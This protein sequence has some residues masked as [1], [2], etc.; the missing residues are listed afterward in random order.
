MKKLLYL[1]LIPLLALSCTREQEPVQGESV[2][3]RFSLDQSDF[4]SLRQRGYEDLINSLELWVF[5]EQGLFV[6]KAKEVV[7]N[8]SA[9]S[10][11]AKI[12]KS[13]APRIIH[14]V[15]NY[16]LANEANWVGHDEKELVPSLTV[17]TNDSHLYMWSRKKY[18]QI[19]GNDNLGEIAVR[20]NMAKFALS[21]TTH[22]LTDVTYTLRNTYDKGTLAPFDP[23]ETDREQ[24]FKKDYVTEPGGV[25][26]ANNKVYQSID[27]FF[28]GFERKNSIIAAGENISCLIVKAKYDGSSNF[29]YYKIDFVDKEDKTKRYDIIRNHFYKVT[30]NDVRKPGYATEAEALA[31]AAANNLA[32]SEELQM[33]PSFSDGKGRLEVDKTYLAF[34]ANQ[35]TGTLQVKYYPESG[36]TQTANDR[37]T[38]SSS[39]DAVASASSNNNGTI[40]L[41]LNTAP[42]SG[43]YTSDVIVGVNDNPDLKRLVRILVR[44]PY[45]YTPFLVKTENT[46]GTSIVTS[47]ASNN[48]ANCQVYSAQ[49]KK[50]T[51]EMT[52][53]EDFSERLLPTTFRFKTDHFYPSGGQGMIFGNEDSHPYYEYK[54]ATMPS[55]RKIVLEFKSNKAASAGDIIVTSRF[56]YFY[57]QTIHV[58]N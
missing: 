38:I 37:I 6:E 30:I 36:S 4:S 1:L 47:T 48:V 3:V 35:T 5:D 23:A 33:Y 13:E 22:K 42:T 58:T 40:T 28:Y 43:S 14:F 25:S 27:N 18:S 34:T 26:F 16:T 7:Y 55:D 17:E 31:G 54:V 57:Q 9:M 21:V 10:F 50:L 56:G 8:P 46:S 53:S 20:R 15:T 51:V 24:T 2:Q 32:L 45:L 19:V 11:T 52:L 41:N 39:G 44:K 12:S 49:G 29:S